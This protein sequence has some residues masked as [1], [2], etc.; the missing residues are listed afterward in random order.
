MTAS[1]HRRAM[2]D[3]RMQLISGRIED[4]RLPLSGIGEWE[5]TRV[6]YTDSE[7]SVTVESVAT[8]DTAEGPLKQTAVYTFRLRRSGREDD[9]WMVMRYDTAVMR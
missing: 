1:E 8:Y 6:N 2:D 7:G 3:Y 4:D 9:Q 5:I